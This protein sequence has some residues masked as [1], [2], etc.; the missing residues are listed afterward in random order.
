[1]HTHTHVNNNNNIIVHYFLK[2]LKKENSVQAPP[3]NPWF[4]V[5]LNPN[6]F[7]NHWRTKELCLNKRKGLHWFK[8]KR[9]QLG[10]I[11]DQLND[12]CTEC[13]SEQQRNQKGDL[14]VWGLCSKPLLSSSSRTS[15]LLLT[16]Y[17]KPLLPF[18]FLD[19]V[20]SVLRIFK[21]FQRC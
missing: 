12:E 20:Y 1:M 16:R 21:A 4:S 10:F 6:K 17:Q 15:L 5:I 3:P 8:K 13:G 11:S 19:L 9:K 2:K 14:L 7:L 18:L